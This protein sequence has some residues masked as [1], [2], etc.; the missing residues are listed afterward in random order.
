[1]S[2]RSTSHIFRRICDL[3]LGLDMQKTGR[4]HVAPCFLDYLV[5]AGVPS[6]SLAGCNFGAGH[7]IRKYGLEGEYGLPVIFNLGVSI[8]GGIQHYNLFVI[9][10]FQ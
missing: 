2:F 4:I 10:M 7:E 3:Y 9:V 1:M 8:A 5:L 6:S